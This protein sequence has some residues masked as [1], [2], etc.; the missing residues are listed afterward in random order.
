MISHEKLLEKTTAAGR[1]TAWFKTY[2]S[3]HTQSVSITGSDGLITTAFRLPINQGVFQCS[4]LGPVLFPN[5]TGPYPGQ[6]ETGL[7]KLSDV[8]SNAPLFYPF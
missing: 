7:L 6:I 3:G 5:R 4:S 1:D 2:L 8:L